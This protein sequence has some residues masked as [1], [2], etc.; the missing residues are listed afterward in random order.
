MG[1]EP[2]PL[3]IPTNLMKLAEARSDEEHID[4]S[5]AL[6]QLM[7]KGAEE[8]ILELI[9]RGRISVSRAAE[10]LDTNPHEI[11][12]LAEKKD[13]EIGATMSQY[14]KGEKTAEEIIED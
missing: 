10:L 6:R 8:Y 2:Y 12:R 3:R 7:Y 4:K 14:E 11:H 5:T 13:V 9:S 1:T